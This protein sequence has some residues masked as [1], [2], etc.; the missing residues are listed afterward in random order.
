MSFQC[1][2][3]LPCCMQQGIA[4]CSCMG[5]LLFCT[6]AAS[7]SDLTRNNIEFWQLQQVA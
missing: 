3:V 2:I 7:A 5:A 4:V 6:A 1:A